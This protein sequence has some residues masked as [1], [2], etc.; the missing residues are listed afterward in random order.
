MAKLADIKAAIE[1]LPEEER[2]A[3]ASWLA[4]LDHQAWDAEI[5]QDFSAGGAGMK[6]LEEVDERIDRGN[7]APLG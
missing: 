7:F 1:E 2:T 6:L 5:A 3:L 4:N